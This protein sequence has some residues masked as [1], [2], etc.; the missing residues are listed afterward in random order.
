MGEDEEEGLH[1]CEVGEVVLGQGEAA[2][3][4][5]EGEQDQLGSH[6]LV[7]TLH[8]HLLPLQLQPVTGQCLYCSGQ[9]R[10]GQVKL[11]SP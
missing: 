2:H 5:Q 6:A 3:L 11:T 4:G 1:L 9:V 8:L 10:S 7:L